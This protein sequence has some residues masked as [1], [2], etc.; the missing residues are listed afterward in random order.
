MKLISFVI[1]CYRSSQTICSVVSEIS[2]LFSKNYKNK[3]DYEI[4][5]V[6]DAS[7]DDT[8]DKIKE[9]CHINKKV[10]GINLAKNFGQHSALMAGFRFITG[11]YV[12]CLDDD[13]QTP[14]NQVFE[15]INAIEEGYDVVYAQYQEKR[16]SLFRN[17]GSRIND[18]MARILINKPKE[19]YLSSYFACRAY[20]IK[21]MI[22]YDN[23]YPYMMGLVLRTTINITNVK[24]VH[25]ERINGESGYTLKSLLAL[26]LNGF[27]NFSV[28]PLRIASLV[29]AILFIISMVFSIVLFLRKI[30]EPTIQM[31]YTSIMLTMIL[32]GSI[33][34]LSIGL[35]GEY[36]GRIFICI[37]KSPQYVIKEVINSEEV[38]ENDEIRKAI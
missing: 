7:P 26:W 2:S 29:G 16:H 6:N 15:L 22:K 34:L 33:Q 14:A 25:R 38:I 12:V 19:L 36:I 17:I 30:F 4:I 32:F 13:G 24:V 3:Y 31:G 35:L 28:K 8:L 18:F 20:V 21:E 23:A 1:P 11:E 5:L 9:I 27:T 10:K 37:N